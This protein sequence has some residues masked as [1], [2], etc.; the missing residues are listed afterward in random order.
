MAN[1]SITSSSTYDGRKMILTCT[2]TQNIDKNTSTINWTLTTQGGGVNYYSTGPTTVTINGEEVY[3]KARTA[4]SSQTFPAAKGSKSGS[5]T[6]SH[7]SDGKKSIT[8]SLKTA[9]Y[10]GSA[11]VKTDS[12]TWTLDT[13]PRAA[14]LSSATAFNDEGNPTI[15]YS[16][17]AGNSVST[18]QAFIYAK[19]DKTVL[20]SG[21]D[22][23]KT[24]TSFT[25]NLTNAERTTLRN[26]CGNAKSTTVK[27]YIKTVI[28]SN[29]FW[30]SAID[31][32]FS[33]I[34]GTPTVTCSAYDSNPVAVALT[35]DSGKI[36]KGFNAVYVAMTSSGVKGASIV[37]EY[38]TNNGKIH[39][40]TAG[41]IT[42]V[43]NG[44][45]GFYA[46][47]NRG[48]ETTKNVTLP[49]INYVALTNSFN[50][51]M[52]ADG[53]MS[54]KIEGNYFNASFGAQNNSLT[55]QY[56]YK[57]EEDASFSAWTSVTPTLSGNTYS[58]TVSIEGFDYQKTYV[59]Q[60]RATD[61]VK[62]V[63]ASQQK[64]NAYPIFD[65]GEKDFNF[66]VPVIIQGVNI[67]DAIK[68]IQNKVGL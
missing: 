29:T 14:K 15:T 9:I 23:S 25:F 2:Q 46:K 1:L 37:N 59:V 55:V 51:K 24:G 54:I 56:R 62:T 21:K 11:S 47:D 3:Y 61:K 8:V 6:V 12:K 53:V 19:D 33:I 49:M 40:I 26:A 57:A 18:L 42:N 4:Y 48:F 65:W 66:N 52:T 28:G 27:F 63:T 13:I 60:T 7:N 38:I 34:N 30:S 67:L 45:F 20:V 36:I 5:L 50:V 10:Y 68:A 16:N 64:I 32:T 44:T 35:G 17:S 41:T 22:I 39:D 31:K 58:A 43:T